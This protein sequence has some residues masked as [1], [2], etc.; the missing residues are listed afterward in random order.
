MR[1]INR[2]HISMGIGILLAIVLLDAC[3]RSTQPQ[4]I[5]THVVN[6]GDFTLAISESGMLEALHSVTITSDLPSNQAKISWLV[7][8]G[9]YVQ[10]GDLLVKFD[11]APFHENIKKIEMQI[12]EADGALTQARQDLK[13]HQAKTGEDEAALQHALRLAEMEL[14]NLV[15]GKA[16]LQEE[17]ARTALLHAEMEWK[18]AQQDY[19]DLQDILNGGF[20]TRNEVARAE[21]Q[22]AEAK[23][24]YELAREKFQ[25][26]SEYILPSEIEKAKAEVNRRREDFADR[27][28]TNEFQ[29]LRNQAT[30]ERAEA[31]LASEQAALAE[32]RAMLA[33][34]E[35]KA[36]GPGFVIFQEVPVLGTRR[37]VQV[38][39]QVWL[40]QGFILLP[41]ISRMAVEIQVR[42]VD[43]NKVEK[44]QQAEIRVEAYPDLQLH[45]EVDLIGTLAKSE[46]QGRSGKFFNVRVLA[47][48][49]DQRLRPGMT[50]RVRI[51]AREKN[52]V[53][54]I[55]VE[56][57]FERDGNFYSLVDQG[58][59]VAARPV[60]VGDSDGNMAVIEAG[61][62][63]G[64]RVL[65]GVPA[66]FAW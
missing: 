42:E 50:A 28:K 59:R 49:F 47:A 48:E 12:R 16:P 43:I 4:A 33:R 46:P 54:L 13:L 22:A 44:G 10:A 24:N 66:D 57:V 32:T 58:G 45:G 6:R 55:P 19:E 30:V 64:D 2:N 8:E 31:K 7:E 35:I 5:P 60:T 65:L 14:E 1:L 40:N 36:P 52:G 17:E 18:Q 34:T 20:V 56:A 15:K 53:L 39:D 9:T 27:K 11:P 38:G 23:S 62:A 41:D 3:N 21:R 37:K 61:L 25:V 63:E 29:G 51:I 26:Y